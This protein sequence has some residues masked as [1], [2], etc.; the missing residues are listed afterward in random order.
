MIQPSTTNSLHF[1]EEAFRFVSTL[2][3]AK[4]G[5]RRFT[6]ALLVEHTYSYPIKSFRNQFRFIFIFPQYLN[7][8]V[9][10][11]LQLPAVLHRVEE[12]EPI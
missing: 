11:Q 12:G 5:I 10:I 1:E 8:A 4:R 3:A 2:T 6:S 9:L 7:L